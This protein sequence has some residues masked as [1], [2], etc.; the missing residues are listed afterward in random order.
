MCMAQ[1][2]SQYWNR[3][4]VAEARRALQLNP[5]SVLV[6]SRLAQDLR[7]AWQRR[8]GISDRLE[9]SRTRILA[10]ALFYEVEVISPD[11]Q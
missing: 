1:C 8:R 7:R 6:N 2:C 5:N 9:R 10:A 11:P 3:R 4:S